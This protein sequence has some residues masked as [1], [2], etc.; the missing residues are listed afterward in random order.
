[1]KPTLAEEQKQ[2]LQKEFNAQFE[3]A[4]KYLEKYKEEKKACDLFMYFQCIGTL[5]TLDD[6]LDNE[7]IANNEEFYNF[8]ENEHDILFESGLYKTIELEK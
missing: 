6:L 5:D 4:K 3:Y 7:N 2:E 8:I 1:M